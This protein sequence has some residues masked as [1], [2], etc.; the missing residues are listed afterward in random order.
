MKYVL[1]NFRSYT[2]SFSFVKKWKYVTNRNMYFLLFPKKTGHHAMQ[3][4][5]NGENGD[6]LHEIL[7]EKSINNLSLAQLS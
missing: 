4:V 6:Y 7:Y 3:I 1:H 5:S 2:Y